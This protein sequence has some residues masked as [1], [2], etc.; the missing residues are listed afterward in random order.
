MLVSCAS[1]RAVPAFLHSAH[2]L[3]SDGRRSPVLSGQIAKQPLPQL[4]QSI[5]GIRYGSSS[6]FG[7]SKSRRDRTPTGS[8]EAM[9]AGNR[10][11][12][13]SGL[14]SPT[15]TVSGSPCPASSWS[16]FARRRVPG[17][18]VA[19]ASKA[20]AWT[21]QSSIR[22]RSW[23]ASH[24]W[25]RSQRSASWTKAKSTPA[26]WSTSRAATRGVGARFFANKASAR[27]RRSS[28]SVAQTS[29]ALFSAEVSV[30]RVSGNL[31][32]CAGTRSQ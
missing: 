6:P 7:S 24:P 32:S 14:R 4:F 1:S 5:V 19:P 13:R 2:H 20:R 31:K 11:G 21:H 25:S 16:S 15:Q 3:A 8:L 28:I 26:A 18:L 12:S 10:S 30:A 23:R 27:A 22:N 17:R 9:L 29:S